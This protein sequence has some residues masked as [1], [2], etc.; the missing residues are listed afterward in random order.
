VSRRVLASAFAVYLLGRLP[1]FFEPHWYTDEAGYT[2]TAQ[3]ILNGKLLYAS[4]WNNKPPL[5]LW[6][7]AA[8]VRLFGPSEA[9]LHLL[10]LIAGLMTLAAVMWAAPKLIGPG[11]ATWVVLACAVLLGLPL[12]DSELALPETLLA[13]PAAWAGS[14]LLA[15][16][17]DRGHGAS[18]R[19]WWPAAVGVLAA[20][21]VAYQQTALADA[22]AFGLVLSFSPLVRGREVALY[23]ISLAVPTAAWVLTVI[24]L[25]GGHNVLFALAGFYVPYAGYTVPQAALARLLY[26]AGLA[27][28]VVLAI[29]GAYLRR[30]DGVTWAALLWA[31]FALLV[32][33]AAQRPYPHF[34]LPS[35]V[36][37][38]LALPLLVRRRWFSGL[39]AAR[40]GAAAMG[41]AVLLA[42]VMAH[43]AGV[44]WIPPLS[45]NG[46]NT[47]RTLT[48]YY[49]DF[50]RVGSLER[51]QNSFDDRVAGDRAVALWVKQ[52]HLSGATAVVWSSDAWLY[53]TAELDQVM[54]T[55]P[56]YNDFVLLGTDGQVSSRV[57]QLAPD[58]II[59]ANQ[60]SDEFPEIK[61]VLVEYYRPVFASGPDTVWLRTGVP[62]P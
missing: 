48:A 57:R 20:V 21:A 39:V 16:L 26:L 6:T 19:G 54:P 2:A 30:R 50:A 27:A 55:A 28:A 1:S 41:A 14:L 13:A 25:A 51:W 12:F 49:L 22:V 61:P 4:I 36:P 33:A 62:D 8:A 38:A 42:G 34:L 58:L 32:P 37:L 10:T 29:A 46:Y 44:D 40:L 11:R 45:T 52:N 53:A 3:G 60:D 7:V 56:I 5:H 24:A 31:V 43:G 9:G 35:L 15:K 17:H 59:V 23:A 47:Y 18:D